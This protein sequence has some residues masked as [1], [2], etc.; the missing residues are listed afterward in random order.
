VNEKVNIY[1]GLGEVLPDPKPED[2]VMIPEDQDVMHTKMSD[3]SMTLNDIEKEFDRYIRIITPYLLL[4]ENPRDIRDENHW[5]VLFSK[6]SFALRKAIDA[7]S[8]ILKYDKMAKTA[9]KGERA[10]AKLDDF[11]DF[12]KSREGTDREVKVTDP[13]RSAFADMHKGVRGAERR[14][15]IV[16]AMAAKLSHMKFELVQAISTLKAMHSRYR[17]SD[18][19]SNNSVEAEFD[20]Q[21]RQEGRR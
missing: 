16:S 19:L 2:A 14:E 11:P 17:D 6:L 20:G 10:I 3:T 18:M 1:E 15:A 5:P 7:L 8:W 9:I 12:A 4:L 13:N 21:K